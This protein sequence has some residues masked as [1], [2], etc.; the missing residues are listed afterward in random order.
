MKWSRCAG[1]KFQ[2]LQPGQISL[3][4]YMGK[5][6]FIPAKRDMFP[7]GICLQK[8]IGDDYMIPPCRDEISTHP[9]GTDFI[10][11]LHGEINFHHGKA[12][13]VSTRYLF[14]KTHRFP[15]I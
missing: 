3:Y 14:T 1:M 7:P 4:D 5:S 10:L 12:R 13:Q 11:R 2:L 9:A 15:L 8:L 6:I